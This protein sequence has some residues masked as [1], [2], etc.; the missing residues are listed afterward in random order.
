MR[1]Y[2][3]SATARSIE[4]AAVYPEMSQGTAQ[5]GRY[6]LPIVSCLEHL[7]SVPVSP[8]RFDSA[9]RPLSQPLHQLQA[10][11]GSLE[12][13]DAGGAVRREQDRVHERR[14]RCVERLELAE[15]LAPPTVQIDHR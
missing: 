8:S 4:S 13:V 12:R 9:D 2:R 14:A 1:P 10:R 11:F 6:S 15:L 7:V 5:V 3:M